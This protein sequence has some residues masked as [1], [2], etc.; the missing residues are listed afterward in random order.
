VPKPQIAVIAVVSIAVV[1]FSVA[2]GTAKRA[3]ALSAGVV[4]VFGTNDPLKVRVQ[5]TNSTTYV[6]QPMPA[7]LEFWSGSS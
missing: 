7:R 5:L 2:F 4:E 1:F 3:P 6:Y